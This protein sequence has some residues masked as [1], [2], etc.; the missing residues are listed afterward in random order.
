MNRNPPELNELASLT[1]RTSVRRNAIAI[2]QINYSA[3]SRCCAPENSWEQLGLNIL[4]VDQ[5]KPRWITKSCIAKCWTKIFGP[6]LCFFA[7]FVKNQCRIQFIADYSTNAG[8]TRDG[9]S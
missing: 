3:A 4:R 7:D 1:I 2:A 6:C 8:N 9:I 5:D